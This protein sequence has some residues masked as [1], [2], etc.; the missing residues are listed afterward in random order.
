MHVVQIFSDANLFAGMASDLNTTPPPD[1]NIYGMG[2]IPKCVNNINVLPP[3][4]PPLSFL[5]GNHWRIQGGVPGTHTPPG[6][7]NFFI[8]MQF[9][10][11]N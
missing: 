3:P 11:K 8:F 9:S 10:A 2:P 7:P 1:P 4:A 5:H 6:G